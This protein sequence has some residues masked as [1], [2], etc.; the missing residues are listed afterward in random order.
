M[1]IQSK[2]SCEKF[3]IMSSDYEIMVTDYMILRG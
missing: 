2:N 3:I 1:E